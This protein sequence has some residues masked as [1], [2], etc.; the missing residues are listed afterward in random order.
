MEVSVY[1]LIAVLIA[2]FLFVIL[3]RL[4]YLYLEENNVLTEIKN[5]VYNRDLPTI[6]MKSLKHVPWKSNGSF[7]LSVETQQD[8]IYFEYDSTAEAI[9][10]LS[11]EYISPSEISSIPVDGSECPVCGEMMNPLS[12]AEGFRNK[13]IAGIFKTREPVNICIPCSKKLRREMVQRGTPTHTT[14]EILANDWS[15]LEADVD[16]L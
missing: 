8:E 12:G 16:F 1:H 7:Q 5:E 10:M 3:F 14:S 15:E 11:N 13:R 2:V 9:D 4:I 6:K